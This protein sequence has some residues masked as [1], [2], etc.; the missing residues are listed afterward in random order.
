MRVTKKML[1]ETNRSLRDSLW[2]KDRQIAH[3]IT[4]VDVYK[5]PHNHLMAFAVATERITE[6]LAHTISDLKRR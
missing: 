2:E 1:E 4:L 6:A 3:L 5:A